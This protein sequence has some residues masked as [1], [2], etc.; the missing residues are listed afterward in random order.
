[1]QLR[2]GEMVLPFLSAANWG[3]QGLHPRGNFEG[4]V[5]AAS[6]QEWLEAHGLG[7]EAQV[8]PLAVLPGTAMPAEAEADGLGP[9]ASLD[10]K[11][12]VRAEKLDAFFDRDRQAVIADLDAGF[13]RLRG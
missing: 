7:D 8:F 4:F 6:Q 11:I 12:R 2:A 5:R 10:D 13:A 3:G 1:M 9:D